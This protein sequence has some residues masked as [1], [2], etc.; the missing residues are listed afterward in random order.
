MCQMAQNQMGRGDDTLLACRYDVEGRV[1]PDASQ[2]NERRDQV[3]SVH[4][5]S[6]TMSI[7][8]K[9]GLMVIWFARI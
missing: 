7:R 8:G 5:R 4:D 6:K 3:V 1:F 9:H 2:R